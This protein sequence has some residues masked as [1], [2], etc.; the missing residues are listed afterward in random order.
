MDC[1]GADEGPHSH[2]ANNLATRWNVAAWGPGA[3]WITSDF[4]GSTLTL[5]WAD[6][7]DNETGYEVYKNGSYVTTVSRDS[8]SYFFSSLTGGE[9]FYVRALAPYGS[10]YSSQICRTGPSSPTASSSV[11]ASV[12]PNT[13]TALLSWTTNASSGGYTFEWID[14]Y[15]SNSGTK[16]ASYYVPHHGTGATSKSITLGLYDLLPGTYS[17][18]VYTCNAKFNPWNAGSY[19]TYGGSASA[20]LYY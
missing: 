7:N 8:E 16:V 11:S 13:Y 5:N 19:C 6:I 1:S 17:F 2:D 18:E 10:N 9:C 4:G 14:V 12:T 15:H 20:Y 3:V